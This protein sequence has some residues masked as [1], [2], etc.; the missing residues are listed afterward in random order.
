MQSDQERA[1]GTMQKKKNQN[2]N[3]RYN[4]AGISKRYCIAQCLVLRDLFVVV[5]I[6]LSVRVS[7]ETDPAHVV[8]LPLEQMSP[9]AFCI[10]FHAACLFA[11]TI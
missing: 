5:D 6:S 9:F 11:L 2:S 4:I 10:Y 8:F 7:V 1:N 3:H